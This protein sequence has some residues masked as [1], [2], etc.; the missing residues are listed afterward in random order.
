MTS[1]LSMTWLQNFFLQ[2]IVIRTSCQK[3]FFVDNQT[4][5]LAVFISGSQ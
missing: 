2:T 5:R 3:Y 4:A 1:V